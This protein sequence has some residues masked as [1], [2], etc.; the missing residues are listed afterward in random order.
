MSEAKQIKRTLTAAAVAWLRYDRRCL[1]VCLERCPIDTA[2]LYIPDIIGL[3]RDRRLVEIEIKIS[4]ADFKANA[5][6]RAIMCGDRPSVSQF[7]YIVPT[8][9]VGKVEPADGEGLMTLSSVRKYGHPTIEVIKPAKVNAS[10]RKLSVYEVGRMMMHQTGTLHR[11][12]AAM[13]EQQEVA[14]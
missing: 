5:K 13:A 11:A 6:K 14:R 8:K 3:T 10:A 12:L 1:M 4:V 2:G 7:Y 9:L